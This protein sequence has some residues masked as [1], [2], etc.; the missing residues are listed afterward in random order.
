L[1]RKGGVCWLKKG[2]ENPKNSFEGKLNP[3][4]ADLSLEKSPLASLKSIKKA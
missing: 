1:I 2:L 4:K 3:I